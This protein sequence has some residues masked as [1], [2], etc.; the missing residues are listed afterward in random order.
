MDA[1]GTRNPATGSIVDITVSMS[2]LLL[3]KIFST[4]REVSYRSKMGKTNLKENRAKVK[5]TEWD[6]R[7]HRLMD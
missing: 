4:L 6:K 5:G 3:I 7:L 2:L 1:S